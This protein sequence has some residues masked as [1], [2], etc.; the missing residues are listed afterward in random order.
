M[1][2][3]RQMWLGTTD[4]FSAETSIDEWLRQTA[5]RVR[6]ADSL[7]D[8]MGALDGALNEANDRSMV[9]AVEAAE[10]VGVDV[11]A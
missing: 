9:R 2:D 5:E 3:A 8:A 11:Q 10:S 1:D 6:E 7:E 4:A